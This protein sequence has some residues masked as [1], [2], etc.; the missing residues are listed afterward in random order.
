MATFLMSVLVGAMFSTRFFVIAKQTAKFP[1]MPAIA[2]MHSMVSRTIVNQAD[3]IIMSTVWV[4]WV[5]L[6]PCS[7]VVLLKDIMKS[8]LRSARVQNEAKSSCNIAASY[9]ERAEQVRTIK[10]DLH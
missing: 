9:I 3:S 5:V 8:A 7:T 2:M 6:T 4:A 10:T 1:M